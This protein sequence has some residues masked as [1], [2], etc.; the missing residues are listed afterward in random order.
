M[1]WGFGPSLQGTT[2]YHLCYYQ[3]PPLYLCLITDAFLSGQ[4]WLLP[5]L[6]TAAVV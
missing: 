2:N 5:V 4:L 6:R 1:Q 3:S